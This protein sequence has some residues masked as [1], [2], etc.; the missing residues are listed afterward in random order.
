ML[1]CQE[2][3]NKCRFFTDLNEIPSTKD[4]I[5]IWLVNDYDG[6]YDKMKENVN[7]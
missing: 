2:I 3:N 4:I 5:S 1:E 6:W 7:E